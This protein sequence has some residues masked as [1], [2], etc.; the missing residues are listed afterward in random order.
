MEK[1]NDISQEPNK[2]NASHSIDNKVTQELLKTNKFL[3]I[4]S[5][6]CLI[7]VALFIILGIIVH[8]IFGLPAGIFL[9]LCI[10]FAADTQKHKMRRTTFYTIMSFLFWDSVFYA[11]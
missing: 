11:R 1:S 6:G 5:I 4:A 8:G 7:L 3:Y 2:A 9:I 10:I